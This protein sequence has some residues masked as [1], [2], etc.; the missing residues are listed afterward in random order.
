MY[1]LPLID[2]D[3]LAPKAQGAFPGLDLGRDAASVSC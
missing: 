2:K 3:S 1:P